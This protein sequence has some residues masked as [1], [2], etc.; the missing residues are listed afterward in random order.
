[1]PWA[2]A[3]LGG[4]LA[5]VVSPV[6][7]GLAVLYIAAVTGWL[8][9]TLRRSLERV[10]AT[11][12]EFDPVPTGGGAIPNRLSTYLLVGAAVLALLAIWDTSVRGWT[13]LF[14]LALALCLGG[15]GWALRRPV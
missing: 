13:G 12:G 15:V 8:M 4:V 6:W 1:M 5:V 10:R 7:A 9:R 11:Y 3:G 14:G 2:V